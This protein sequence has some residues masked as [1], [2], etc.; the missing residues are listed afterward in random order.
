MKKQDL[1]RLKQ[2]WGL[3]WGALVPEASRLRRKAK[4]CAMAAQLQRS[5]IG[6]EEISSR[7]ALGTP[8]GLSA[9]QRQ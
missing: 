8:S 2:K 5:G 3:K 6:L 7:E 4:R 9:L 1:N